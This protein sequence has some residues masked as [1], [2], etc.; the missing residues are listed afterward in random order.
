MQILQ[1]YQTHG[2]V[3]HIH[4]IERHVHGNGIG[5]KVYGEMLVINGLLVYARELKLNT[6]EELQLTPMGN[7]VDPYVAD[8]YI[9]NKEQYDN[10]ASVHVFKEVNGTLTPVDGRDTP[11][12]EPG[13]SI[14]LDFEALGE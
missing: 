6:L 13:G 9:L 4:Y 14:W 5:I 8:K 1:G 10:Y 7:G 12:P 3:I 2:S 11:G